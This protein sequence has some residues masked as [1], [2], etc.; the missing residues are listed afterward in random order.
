MIFDGVA[1]GSIDARLREC[2]YGV[3]NARPTCIVES[4]TY[5]MIYQRFPNGESYEDVKTRVADFL[6][7]LKQRHDGKKIALVAHKGPQLA[8]D[9]LLAGKTWAEAFAHDWR[10]NNA[11]KPGWNYRLP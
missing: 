11:W 1:P 2:N 7:F 6:A 3:F 9:V 5:K 10:K 8:L 4:M